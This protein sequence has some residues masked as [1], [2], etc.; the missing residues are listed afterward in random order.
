MLDF[1]RPYYLF[2]PKKAENPEQYVRP[3]TTPQKKIIK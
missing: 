2:H 1:S 3:T